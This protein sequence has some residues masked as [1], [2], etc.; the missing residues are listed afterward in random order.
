MSWALLLLTCR[1]FGIRG[2]N[3]E[4]GVYPDIGSNDTS[5]G[6]GIDTSAIELILSFYDL[7]SVCSPLNC[8]KW[9]FGERIKQ[10]LMSIL[11]LPYNPF[12]QQKSFWDRH[13]CAFFPIVPIW[14][15]STHFQLFSITTEYHLKTELSWAMLSPVGASGAKGHYVPGLQKTQFQDTQKAERCVLLCYP[16][17]VVNKMYSEFANWWWFIS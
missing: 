11:F 4:G 9:L 15:N 3:W 5:T 6:F 2:N 1:S 10:T 13:T 17:T 12:K 14:L 8:I 7:N 16:I